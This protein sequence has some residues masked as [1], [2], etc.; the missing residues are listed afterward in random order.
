MTRYARIVLYPLAV[1]GLLVAVVLGVRTPESHAEFVPD[2]GLLVSTRD[3]LRVCVDTHGAVPGG[4]AEQVAAALGTVRAHPQWGAARF[5][6]VP[7][8]ERGCPATLPGPLVRGTVVGPGLTDAPSPYR[9][10][11]VVLDEATADRYL[12]DRPAALL[13]YELMR[14]SDHVVVTVT[15]AVAVRAGALGTAEFTKD[16]LTPALGL[17]PSA[18]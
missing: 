9:T 12:G 1:A 7:A 18:G 5:G 6:D 4:A 3:A 13:P 8:V 11:V 14:V 10:V 15:Q 17:D 16:Y 2:S